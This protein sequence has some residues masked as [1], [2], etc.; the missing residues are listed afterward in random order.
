[1]SDYINSAVLVVLG[2]LLIIGHKNIVNI[3]TNTQ[4]RND[5]IFGSKE[6]AYESQKV[7]AKYII[8]ILGMGFIAVAIL[9]VYFGFSH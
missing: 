6:K 7:V 1:M 3:I 5:Q 9:G 8:I 2:L 4:K